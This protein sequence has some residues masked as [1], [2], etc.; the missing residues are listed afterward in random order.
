VRNWCVWSEGLMW[1]KEELVFSFINFTLFLIWPIVM[2]KKK[3]SYTYGLLYTYT[4]DL[5]ECG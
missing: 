2:R 1:E 5:R 4:N 3:F